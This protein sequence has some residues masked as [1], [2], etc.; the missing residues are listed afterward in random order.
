VVDQTGIS[1]RYDFTLTWTPDETQFAS[2]GIKVPPPPADATAP[3]L[4]TAIQ[5]QLGLK[6]ESA[7]APVDVIVID[8]VQRPSPN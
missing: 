6:F 8:S 7:K 2:M 4:F 5:E 3:T 1:G